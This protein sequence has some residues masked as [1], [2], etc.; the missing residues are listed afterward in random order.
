MIAIHPELD[1]L[2]VNDPPR[3]PVV[4]FILHGSEVVYVG[5]S[6]RPSRRI[7]Q[8]KWNK[9]TFDHVLF[10]P[11]IA[12]E[13]NV[14]ERHWIDTIK[15]KFNG[16]WGKVKRNDGFVGVCVHIC[17]DIN[18]ALNQ[19]VQSRRLRTSRAKVAKVAIEE[20]LKTEG[21]WPRRAKK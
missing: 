16:T 4:Y 6:V 8:H 3:G 5:Q 1:G 17:P 18:E 15:P 13:L 2:L 20:F 12:G 11:V 7:K 9:K 19:F 10:L 21:F 14:V